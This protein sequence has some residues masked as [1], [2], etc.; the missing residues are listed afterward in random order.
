[1]GALYGTFHFLRLLQTLQPIDTLDVSEKPR[2]GLR[3]IDHWDNLDGTIE[4]G[5]AGRSLWNWSAL[6]DSPDPRLRDYAR[7][8]SI[9]INGC[10]LNNVNANSQFLSTEYLRKASAIADIF[11][12]YGVRVYLSPRFS[13]PIELDGMK[14]ADPLDPE[15]AA[16][17]KK[18]A[19]EIYKLIPDFGGFLVKANSEGQPGPRTYNRNHVDGANMMAAA[20]APHNGV[21]I[22]RAF[23]YDMKPGY[24]RAG[25][26][27][28]N[29]QPFDGKFVPRRCREEWSDRSASR[30]VSPAVCGMPKTQMMPEFHLPELWVFKSLAFWLRCGARC[31]TPTLM[32]GP[33]ST[34]ARVADG[35]LFVSAT[36]S[37]AW[38]TRAPIGTG[39]DTISARPTGMRSA[40]WPGIPIWHPAELPASGSG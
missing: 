8:A 15:V 27:Y 2:L 16:W 1:V 5:Y 14:T 4:R 36:G 18:K 28:E 33:G 37:Q 6:P 13:A 30:A 7:P 17:W 19:D 12:A 20:L 35:S 3:I 31:S 32:R 22:W 38:P 11:R 39:R 26:A 24:D 25:A 40:A 23:V 21:V 34:I 29:L 10:V 9:G